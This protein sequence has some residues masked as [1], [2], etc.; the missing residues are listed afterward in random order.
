MKYKG[1]TG[2]VVGIDAKTGRIYGE[3]VDI[4]GVITFEADNG[5]DLVREFRTSVDLHLAWCARR[6][7]E[8]PKPQPG[9]ILAE[10]PRSLHKSAARKAAESG[11]S[12]EELFQEAVR[13]AV[14]PATKVLKTPTKVVYKTVPSVK[15]KLNAKSSKPSA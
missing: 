2:Q 11:V 10:L 5:L 3:V 9:K 13:V 12:V 14:T 6:H 1:Y 8:P 15:G 7:V 4:V